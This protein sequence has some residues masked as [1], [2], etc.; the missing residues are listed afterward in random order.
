MNRSDARLMAGSVLAVTVPAMLLHFTTSA[1]RLAVG[2]TAAPF[3][4]A[5]RAGSAP[6]YSATARISL[7]KLDAVRCECERSG[8]RNVAGDC[9]GT[10]RFRRVVAPG[11]GESLAAGVFG[12]SALLVLRSV[13]ATALV[14][15]WCVW[16][17]DPPETARPNRQPGL[18]FAVC[19]GFAIVPCG[20][21]A[22]AAITSRTATANEHI[23]LGRLVKAEHVLTGLVELGS[24]RSVSAKASG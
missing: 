5:A 17:T 23:A 12:E 2:L 14:L 11:I 19:A 21:Y 20:L 10:G 3:C 1:D 22:D 4:V 13:L 15:P 18:W 24:D 8:P 6:D 9:S 16:V 7:G